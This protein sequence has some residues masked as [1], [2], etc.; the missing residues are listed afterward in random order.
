MKNVD[1]AIV[2]GLALL[3]AQPALA[4]TSP[5]AV[6][7]VQRHQAWR[8]GAAYAAMRG[9]HFSGTTQAA[10]LEG[11]LD[12]RLDLS[13]TPTRVRVERRMGPLHQMRGED[14]QGGWAMTLSGQVEVI[15]SHE[16][17]RLALE[18]ALNLGRLPEGAA[19]VLVGQ[20]RIEGRDCAI[21][22]TVLPEGRYAL[23]I[24]AQSGALCGAR[25]EQG[26]ETQQTV[27][28]DWRRV[29][30]V[31]MAFAS[32]MTDPEG[33][34]EHFRADR[35]RVNPRFDAESF[36]RPEAVRVVRFEPGR[37]DSGW[38]DFDFFNQ[39]QIFIPATI[40]GREAAVMLD[41]GAEVTLIDKT[42]AEELGIIGEGEIPTLGT[43]GSDQVALARGVDIRMGDVTLKNLTVGLY[44]FVP[45]AAALGRPLP[46]L[47][48]K[49][50]M[51]EA[52][53]DIDFAARRIRVIDRSDYQPLPEARELKLVTTSGLRALPVRIEDGPEV[54][55]M[56]DLGSGAPMTL[57]PAYAAEQ[58]LL[59]GRPV[60]E[61]R[62]HGVGGASTVSMMT[63]QRLTLAGFDVD[64][65]PASVPPLHGVWVRDVAAANLG[66]PLFSRFRL[67]MDFA[68]DRLFLAPGPD[69][70]APF[71]RD[72][73][74]LMT[75]AKDGKRLIA[76]VAPSSPAA[77][78]GLKSGDL[79]IDID[80][81]GALPDSGWTR[82][83][84]GRDVTLT[85]DGGERRHLILADYF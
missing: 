41:T 35:V 71:P 54:L 11:R 5:T 2:A 69:F 38:L 79:I 78:L 32:V 40:R 28:S 21:V 48:G 73:A 37:S 80:G 51:N 74:G 63:V 6:E 20:E 81:Q 49:E 10:G 47:L 67:A 43:S 24:E 39:R 44:D 9:A 27:F 60:S 34:Q 61:A 45:L 53:V 33:R 82:G 70:A 31:R 25:L 17:R 3:A 50:V 62:S 84:A 46:V 83:A 14:A 18:E 65:V 19:P 15:S 23:L 26:E 22:E 76:F 55:G 57:F 1:T 30:G 72:R 8:G 85:L 68:G 7:L 12:R 4:A 75:S 13:S 29:E 58:G 16:H 66:L 36:A 56:F 59:A 77:A 64:A 52:V 42:L